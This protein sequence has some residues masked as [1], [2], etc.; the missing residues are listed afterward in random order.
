M[1]LCIDVLFE[2]LQFGDRRRL[3]K[4]EGVG[5]RFH[6][7]VDKWFGEMPFIRLDIKLFGFAVFRYKL[8]FV[9]NWFYFKSWIGGFYWNLSEK[10]FA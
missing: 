5:R 10:D 1:T 9:I 8:K 6:H 2:I 3:T 7:L 4:M